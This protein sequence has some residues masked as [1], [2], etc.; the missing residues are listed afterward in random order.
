MK[1]KLLLLA[2]ALPFAVMSQTY[3]KLDSQ[4]LGFTVT[5]DDSNPYKLVANLLDGLLDANHSWQN[6]WESEATKN[7]PHWATIDMKEYTSIDGVFMIAKD[8]DSHDAAPKAGYIQVMDTD[9]PWLGIVAP[10]TIPD[11]AT[12][13]ADLPFAGINAENIIPLPEFT[14][15]RF[16]R[17]TFTDNHR[18]DFGY[19]QNGGL[20][21]AEMGVVTKDALGVKDVTN[22]GVSVKAY[23]NPSSNEFSLNIASKSSQDV[24]VKVFD[25]S[26][27]LVSTFKT[28]SGTVTFGKDLNAGIYMVEIA[29]DNSK[30]TLKLIKK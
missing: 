18:A 22:N 20:F 30:Q 13:F 23:P 26:G 9:G 25:I 15:G 5:A 29:Q 3:T 27:K 4:A 6:N 19:G 12:G 10:A 2:M 17:V 7:F 11:D 14:N 1:N 16:V 28:A 8:V 21:V 24:N